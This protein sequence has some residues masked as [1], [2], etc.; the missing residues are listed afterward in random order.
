MAALLCWAL[1]NRSSKCPSNK[2]YIGCQYTPG[3]S[4]STWVTLRSLSHW[5]RRSTS[6]AMVLLLVTLLLCIRR[7]GTGS[8]TPLVD[9]KTSAAFID[10][11]HILPGSDGEPGSNAPIR[12]SLYPF[13]TCPSTKD[14]EVPKMGGKMSYLPHIQQIINMFQGTSK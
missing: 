12:A 14:D 11:I 8:H 1:T 9:S 13:I 6:G 5:C 2:A 10:N 4:M 7:A 3:E